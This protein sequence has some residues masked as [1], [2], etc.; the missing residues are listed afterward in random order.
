MTT[1]AA[2]FSQFEQWNYF[3]AF[4]YCFI[5]LTTIGFGDYVALQKDSALQS[6]PQYVAFS[7]IFIL[8]GL[9][10]VSAAINLL[11]L[12]FLTLNTEDERRDEAEAAT[13]AQAAVRLEGD[14]ITAN[15]SVLGS[16]EQLQKREDTYHN[17]G[18]DEENISVCSCT[19]YGNSSTRYWN[20]STS[21]SYVDTDPYNSKPF[22][23]TSP[24]VRMVRYY[25][26]DDALLSM[27]VKTISEMEMM[28]PSGSK[29]KKRKS[30]DGKRSGMFKSR[31]PGGSFLGRFTRLGTNQTERP[32]NN[33]K[34]ITFADDDDVEQYSTRAKKIKP[35]KSGGF[36][37]SSS[38][39]GGGGSSRTTGTEFYLTELSPK[40][41]AHCSDNTR[42]SFCGGGNECTG[43]G[44]CS[45]MMTSSHSS[46]SRTAMFITTPVPGVYDRIETIH[47]NADLPFDDNDD[48]DDDDDDDGH[49]VNQRPPLDTC[50]LDDNKRTSI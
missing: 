17:T 34:S 50:D 23:R 33:R 45:S 24:R 27:D 16:D 41:G 2:A 35:T 37:C 49:H 14:V 10:V 18:L 12:R 44:I 3:D 8:F 9:S 21:R 28:S 20:A 25:Y 13:A 6:N 36:G 7:L 31:M 29:K 42:M 46:S 19:C 5:T 11:V 1:G 15:G 32:V 30:K 47:N 43:T 39:S 40:G 22:V 4:Y 26:G 38:G 48:Y